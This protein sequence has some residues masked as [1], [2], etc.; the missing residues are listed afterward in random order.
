MS[1]RGLTTIGM[2]GLFLLVACDAAASRAQDAKDAKPDAKPAA[3]A[4]KPAADAKPADAKPADAKPADAKPADAKPEP[5]A[6][7]GDA[8]KQYAAKLAEWKSVLKEMRAIKLKFQTA[9]ESETAAIQKQWDDAVAHGEKVLAELR[10]TG[11]AAFV[12]A[13]NVDLQLA[14]FLVKLVAD[15]VERDNYEAAASLADTLVEHQ[16]EVT[17]IYQY[18][19]TVAFCLNQFDK[20]EKLFQKAEEVNTLNLDLPQK[21]RGSIKEYKKLWA[22]E[23]ALRKAEAEKNDLPRVKL[24]TSQGE[25]VIELFENEA[26]ETVGNF[27]SLVEKKFYDGLSFHRVLANFMAQGGC[28]IGNGSGDAGYKIYCECYKDNFRKHFRGTLSMAHA[29]K[30]TGGS[31]FFLTFIPTA[32]LNGKH[33]VFGRVVE[34][35]DVL[36]KIHRI[37][38]N[39]PG[40]KSHADKIVKAEVIRKRD[41]KYEPNKVQ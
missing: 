22:E 30:D 6:D 41:H 26:P 14:R 4:A 35:F 37:D 20:A 3:E 17:D 5:A 8:A 23:E 18:A 11:A 39:D 31:Q 1:T 40:A 25:I 15:D 29:G 2:F 13:P 12:A 16:C 7:G 9:P 10:V 24:T 33:T 34:G 19:A 27:I 36:A 28:P 21:L 32:H 38:P